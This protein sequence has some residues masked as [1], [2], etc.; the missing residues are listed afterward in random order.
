MK[1]PKFVLPAL[2]SVLITLLGPVRAFA[3]KGI[4]VTVNNGYRLTA[5]CHYEPD[6]YAEITFVEMVQNQSP[7]TLRIPERIIAYNDTFPVTR[8]NLDIGDNYYIRPKPGVIDFG[9]CSYIGADNNLF[10]NLRKIIIN[11]PVDTLDCTFNSSKLIEVDLTK[12]RYIMPTKYFY[13][14]EEL[15]AGPGLFQNCKSLWSVKFP[16]EYTTISE[17]TF[18]GSGIMIVDFPNVKVIEKNAFA[19]C[20]RLKSVTLESVDSI[21][22]GAFGFCPKLKTVNLNRDIVY[23]WENIF[24]FTQLSE[25]NFY[26][27]VSDNGLYPYKGPYGS[28]PMSI[29]SS[30]PNLQSLSGRAV[31][32]LHTEESLPVLNTPELQAIRTNGVNGFSLTGMNMLRQIDLEDCKIDTIEIPQQLINGYYDHDNDYLPFYGVSLR[33]SVVDHVIIEGD[34]RDY[35]IKDSLL[36]TP[37]RERDRSVLP[38]DTVFKSIDRYLVVSWDVPTSNDTVAV[39][40]VG[41][42]R[43]EWFVPKNNPYNGVTYCCDY[44]EKIRLTSDFDPIGYSLRTYTRPATDSIMVYV[45]LP[46]QRSTDIVECCQSECMIFVVPKGMWRKYVGEGLPPDRT[47]ED[48]GWDAIEVIEQDELSPSVKRIY[49]IDGRLVPEGTRMSPGI[50]IIDGKKYYLQ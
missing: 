20:N 9:Q 30:M 39:A 38:A 29:V 2:V 33:G 43:G 22:D 49:T 28:Y 1:R 5:L 14:G 15:C 3:D 42:P 31:H 34:N 27:A 26:N 10:E 32:Y 24:V 18:Y 46:P 41:F 48:P 17:K 16:P 40:A 19:D 11:A 23:V 35:C 13:Q 6:Q 47:Q 37:R 8:C 25:L 44:V 45:E 50:Y 7:D 4:E 21:G 36:L 12:V